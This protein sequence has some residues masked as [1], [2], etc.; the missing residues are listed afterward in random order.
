MEKVI[1]TTQ[2]ELSHLIEQALDKVMQ[3]SSNKESTDLPELLN[4]TQAAAYLNFA[5]QTL[6]GYTSKGV[7][8]HLKKGKKLYFK[9]S[10]LV[11]WVN[12][13]KQI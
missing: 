4:I 12:E 5:K 7:I 1:V 11:K 2:S 13:G 9:R 6:Y 3:K 10:E 8:P